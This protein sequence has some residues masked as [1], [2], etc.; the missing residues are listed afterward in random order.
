MGACMSAP[1]GVPGPPVGAYVFAHRGKEGRGT[2]YFQP[3]YGEENGFPVH[4]YR[5][6]VHTVLGGEKAV[7]AAEQQAKAKGTHPCTP[8]PKWTNN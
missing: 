6:Y 8:Y 5:V 3:C 1:V 2:L 7:K 4:T